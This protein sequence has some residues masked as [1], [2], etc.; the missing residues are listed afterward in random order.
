MYKIIGADR[1]EYGPVTLEQLRHWIAEGR[2]NRQTSAKSEADH[3]WRPLMSIPELAGE[4]APPP[5]APPPPAQVNS[6]LNVVIPYRNPCA[7]IAYYLGVFSVIPFIGIVLGIIGFV[8]GI[9]GLR[10]R[11][12]NPAAGGVIHA[13]IG[14]VAGGLFGFGWLVLTIFIIVAAAR[15]HHHLG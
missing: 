10:A 9:L 5:I 11:R 7:L 8:L 1:G 4:F 13:W 15:T 3:D 6:G 12:R 2:V 14:I